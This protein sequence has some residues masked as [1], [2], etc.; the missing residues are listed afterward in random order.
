MPFRLSRQ[1]FYILAAGC[2]CTWICITYIVVKNGAKSRRSDGDLYTQDG[3]YISNEYDVTDE[4]IQNVGNWSKNWNK[5]A[6]NRED[7]TPEILEG[8]DTEKDKGKNEEDGENNDSVVNEEE[9]ENKGEKD[10][11]EGSDEE[12]GF[13]AH[14][15]EGKGNENE[16]DNDNA[17]DG[18]EEEGDGED[19]ERG[20]AHFNDN[21]DVNDIENK[22]TGGNVH[23]QMENNDNFKW[24]QD[25]NEHNVNFQMDNIGERGFNKHDGLFKFQVRDEDS[26]K[27]VQDN[28][29]LYD[30]EENN[31]EEFETDGKGENDVEDTEEIRRRK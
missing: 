24:E 23:A 10:V 19:L 17:E 12:Q 26:E 2:M 1:L 8:G 18:E 3:F 6:F 13:P 31:N 29:E 22:D 14:V 15:I 28:A 30:N 16:E 21:E 27:A 4:P 25:Q 9:S 5:N 20:Q 7:T 11:E